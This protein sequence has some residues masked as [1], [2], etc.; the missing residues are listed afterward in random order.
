MIAKSLVFSAF[1]YSYTPIQKITFYTE[2]ILTGKV[3]L[4]I[5]GEKQNTPLAQ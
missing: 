2:I 3:Y 4:H 5:W 1:F